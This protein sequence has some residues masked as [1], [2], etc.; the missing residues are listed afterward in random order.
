MKT[1]TILLSFLLN[2]HGI[3]HLAVYD[4]QFESCYQAEQAAFDK[5]WQDYVETGKANDVSIQSC[6]SAEAKTVES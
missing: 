5:A 6:E 4:T 1:V 3:V 2:E